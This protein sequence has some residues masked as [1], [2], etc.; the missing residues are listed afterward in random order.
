MGDKTFHM[1]ITTQGNGTGK[2]T[3][4][5]SGHV[6]S[7]YQTAMTDGFVPFTQQS[8]RNGKITIRRWI[9]S[10]W[11]A[12]T[13]GSFYQKGPGGGECCIYLSRVSGRSMGTSVAGRWFPFSFKMEKVAVELSSATAKFNLWSPSFFLLQA[14]LWWQ[15]ERWI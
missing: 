3:R 1:S 12:W 9:K 14:V 15:C 7:K 13:S 2:K 6:W 4:H 8:F 11:S 10:E 5:A